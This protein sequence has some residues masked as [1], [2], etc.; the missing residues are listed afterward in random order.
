MHG[1]VNSMLLPLLLLAVLGPRHPLKML[2]LLFWEIAWKRGRGAARAGT[3]LGR[4]WRRSVTNTNDNQEVS[5]P[6][7]INSP[8][9][10]V[11]CRSLVSVPRGPRLILAMGWFSLCISQCDSPRPRPTMLRAICIPDSNILRVRATLVPNLRAF[12]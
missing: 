9:R 11:L 3:A 10:D 8:Q 12:T 5:G 2:P 6:Q 1:V 4:L 7:K